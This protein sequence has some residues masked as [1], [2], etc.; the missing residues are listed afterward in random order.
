MDWMECNFRAN[1]CYSLEP[2]IETKQF[3]T[4]WFCFRLLH[5]Q[6]CAITYIRNMDMKD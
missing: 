2:L 1:R 5:K 4:L 6:T 3:G